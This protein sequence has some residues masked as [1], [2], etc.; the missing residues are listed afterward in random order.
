MNGILCILGPIATEL[1]AHVSALKGVDHRVIGQDSAFLATDQAQG[2]FDSATGETWSC[3]FYGH[4]FDVER[5][6]TSSTSD[7]PATRLGQLI[8]EDGLDGLRR[9]DGR[10]LVV[11]QNTRTK[12]VII[13]ADPVGNMAVSVVKSGPMVAV[14]T[15]INSLLDLPSVSKEPSPEAIAEFLTCARY[16]LP[17]SRSFYRD[18]DKIPANHAFVLSGDTATIKRYW[19][20]DFNPR[21]RIQDDDQTIVETARQLM[22]DATRRR[23][24][25]DG[26]LAAALSGGFDSSSVVAMMRHID[27]PAHRPFSTISFNFG[28]EDADEDDLIDAVSEMNDTT[29]HRVNVLDS[30]FLTETDDA[31]RANAGPIMESGVLLLWKK[32]ARLQ[33]LGHSVSLSGLGGDE[34]FMGRMNFLADEVIH[35]HWRTAWKEIRAV[36][37]FDSSTGKRT[38]LRKLV[39]ANIISPLEPY[40]LK[41]LRQAKLGHRYPPDWIRQNVID[42]GWLNP[43]LPRAQPPFAKEAYQQDCWEVFYY[44]LLHGGLTYHSVAGNG[45]GVDTRFPLLDRKL[46]EY[47]FRVPRRLKI[48]N[49]RVRYVQQEAMR[50]FLPK[51]LLSDHLKKDFHP[52]LDAHLRKEYAERLDPMFKAKTRLSDDFV[53]WP[54]L[55]STYAAVLAGKAKPYSLWV[56]YCLERWL[57]IR[58]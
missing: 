45:T 21:N 19:M 6:Q 47:M 25:A 14:A 49:G 56:A 44:E 38:S 10:F 12:E 37:P 3:T 15:D 36:F 58:T 2:A 39:K 41:N 29:H 7:K 27:E 48:H 52:V 17:V 40:W 23:M 30:P 34:L 28:S 20:P 33:E 35:G 42:K 16:N 18:I 13:A 5:E 26:P 46:I 54:A 57:Q 1:R 32:K 9:T 51:V 4:L 50:P 24:P 43:S 53:D 55:K 8:A 31:I 22:L 11:F